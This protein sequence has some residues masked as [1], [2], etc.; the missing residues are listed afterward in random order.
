MNTFTGNTISKEIF[1]IFA[2]NTVSLTITV[3]D[4]T[5]YYFRAEKVA[6]SG[7]NPMSPDG[8]GGN[9][10]MN[11]SGFYTVTVT[12]KESSEFTAEINF[13]KGLGL[14]VQ[15]DS[16][17]YI[18]DLAEVMYGSTGYFKNRSVGAAQA[19]L[20]VL[21]NFVLP[22]RFWTAFYARAGLPDD[23]QLS[24]GLEAHM[25]EVYDMVW[26]LVR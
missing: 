4:P 8:Y 15:R 6:S 3:S 21:Y 2:G 24:V 13:M 16:D 10:D 19:V 23:V 7:K 9:E 11:V 17:F 25:R 26:A 14:V 5:Y 12:G 18:Y 22:G 20:K 1:D